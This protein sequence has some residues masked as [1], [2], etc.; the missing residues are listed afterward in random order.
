MV[1]AKCEYEKNIK[2]SNC[3]R[4]T[5][6]LFRAF[7]LILGGQKSIKMKT[8]SQHEKSDL[9]MLYAVFASIMGVQ[10]S[11]KIASKKTKKC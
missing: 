2:S 11:I 5:I 9:D 6:M 7:G 8:F 1:H 4:S 3:R 10:E